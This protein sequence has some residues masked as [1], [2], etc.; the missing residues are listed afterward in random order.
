LRE[1][2]SALTRKFQILQKKYVVNTYPNRGVTFVR[3]EGVFLHHTSGEKYLDLMTNY[4]VNIFGYNHPE[5]TPCL[6]NQM[7]KLITLHGSFNNDM[8]AEAAQALVKRCGGGLSQV[9]FS[10]SGAEANEAALKFAVLATGKKK[11]ISCQGGYHGKTLGALSASGSKK[12]RMPF[13][14][15]LWDFQHIE[16]NN[17]S[18]LEAALDG[19][20]AAFIVEPIQGENGIEV[21]DSGYIRK[22]KEL[23]ES[24]NVLVILD[25]VQTGAGRT[26]YFL[27]SQA[28][29]IS[30]DIVCLG[31]GLAGG[32]PVGATLISP[33]V[34]ENIPKLS[35]TSTLGGNPLAGA[36]I[37]AALKLLD[38]K[39]LFRIGKTGEYFKEGLKK[40]KSNHILEVKGKGLMLGIEVDS[41]RDE[42]L[43]N[44]QK[45]KIL[46]CPAADKVVRFLP[47]Y[48]LQNKHVDQALDTLNR[49]FLAL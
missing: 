31:K 27:A 13:E 19:H 47:P 7:R 35:H 15:L 24:R 33:K 8:R 45:E 26:G 49:V 10:N 4:G 30:Y 28:E 41:M 21:P 14:P 6:L 32:I 42:I 46:A 40:I 34:S 9:Y 3:G 2:I 20:T 16:Y 22:A 39:M 25:E 12:Y 38:E 5:I 36:G 43:K 17:L 11:F 23:C 37:M 29:K 48:I 18:Q 1:D 44:L